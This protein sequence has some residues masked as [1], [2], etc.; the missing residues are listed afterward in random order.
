MGRLVISRGFE[1]GVIAGTRSEF[2]VLQLGF[3]DEAN[4]QVSSPCDQCILSGPRH[5]FS[6]DYELEVYLRYEDETIPT[7][8]NIH[9]IS[10]KFESKEYKYLIGRVNLV[11]VMKLAENKREDYFMCEM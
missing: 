8:V 4:L 7:L 11:D 2:D 3:V 9:D 10:Q 5:S 1:W 6:N